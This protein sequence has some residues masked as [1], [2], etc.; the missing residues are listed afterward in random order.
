MAISAISS[1]DHTRM[2]LRRLRYFVAVAEDLHFTRA[3]ARLNLAQPALSQAVRQLETELGVELLHRN[4]REVRLTFA[5]SVLLADARKLLAEVDLAT[6]RTRAAND[7]V[8]GLLRLG[9]IDSTV[10]ELLPRVL[11]RFHAELPGVTLSLH[12]TPNTEIVRALEVG[13]L[14]V[15]LMRPAQLRTP[16]RYEV[17]GHVTPVLAIAS[18]NP[19]SH[20]DV[21]D[22]SSL[23]TADIIIHER[24]H[25]SDAYDMIVD[26]FGRAGTE[27]NV[28]ATVGSMHTILSLVASDLGIAVVPSDVAGWAREEITFRPMLPVFAPMEMAVAWSPQH[29]NPVTQGFLRIARD[30]ATG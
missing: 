10:Y 21:V 18:S 17:V 14:D 23:R 12:P 8:I 29:L 19:L 16:V 1:D 5:G 20:C 26:A 6:Q 24:A 3:A 28:V 27:I 13:E 11:T 2:D 30:V 9:Y 7:G 4:R 15:G 22:L 25:A